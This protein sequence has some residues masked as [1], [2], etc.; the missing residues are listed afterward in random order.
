[1]TIEQV[2]VWY[3][4]NKNIPSTYPI[5]YGRYLIYREKC[6]KMSFE[7]WN[8]TGWASSNNDCT[9]YCIVK[10]PKTE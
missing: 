6:D 10:N 3:D 4:Y 1:M 2:L 5:K 9:R 8:G 7:T